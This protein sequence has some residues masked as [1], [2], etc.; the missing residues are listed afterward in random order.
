M[1]EFCKTCPERGGENCALPSLRE[2]LVSHGRVVIRATLETVATLGRGPAG[3]DARF[4]SDWKLNEAQNRVEQM[5]ADV[6]ECI[7]LHQFGP[8]AKTYP[9]RTDS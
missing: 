7:E 2:K 6:Q 8:D 4:Q 1:K 9:L 3:D 5:K